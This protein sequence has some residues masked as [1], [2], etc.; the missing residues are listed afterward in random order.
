MIDADAEELS[1]WVPR[2]QDRIRRIPGII[3]VTTDRRM[4][5]LQANVVI[6][7][8]AARFLAAAAHVRE[9]TAALLMPQWRKAQAVV[10]AAVR[11]ALGPSIE[12]V[13]KDAVTTRFTEIVAV[14]LPQ[15]QNGA[16]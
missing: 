1:L 5:G 2:L 3:D 15:G 9:L 13:Q 14:T 11:D 6:D 12:L 10:E 8:R 16:T 7:R 4:A